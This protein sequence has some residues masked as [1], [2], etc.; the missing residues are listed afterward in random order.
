LLE[1][2]VGE[3]DGVADAGRPRRSGPI[4]RELEL[5]LEEPI[6]LPER[7]SGLVASALGH[8]AVAQAQPVLAVLAPGEDLA[9]GADDLQPLVAAVVDAG[10]EVPGDAARG[11]LEEPGL[12]ELHRVLPRGPGERDLGAEAV[13]PQALGHLGGPHVH[14]PVRVLRIRGELLGVEALLGRGDHGRRILR[15]EDALL[16][17]AV[18]RFGAGGEQRQPGGRDEKSAA[19]NGRTLARDFRPEPGRGRSLPPVQNLRDKLLK[20]GLVTAE[21][22][23]KAEKTAEPTRA[24]AAS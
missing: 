21:Q 7:A 22:A 8:A 20:A 3:T 12:G 18:H 23:G 24:R 13:R 6:Q 2:G 5:A 1:W 15:R 16:G 4:E 19:R 9:S 11:R 14:H 10:V 17:G